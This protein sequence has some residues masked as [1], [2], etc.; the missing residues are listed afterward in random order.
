MA[1]C[2]ECKIEVEDY[3]MMGCFIDGVSVVICEYC[4]EEDKRINL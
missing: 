3:E 4:V 1:V 2:P